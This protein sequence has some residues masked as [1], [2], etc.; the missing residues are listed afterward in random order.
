MP[1]DEPV[2]GLAPPCADTGI[3]ALA[4]ASL[5]AIDSAL[6]KPLFARLESELARSAAWGTRPETAGPVVCWPAPHRHHGHT[7]T[8][9][10]EVP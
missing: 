5:R 6:G 3:A 1:G 9:F 10:A 8:S 4:A 2:P 7:P